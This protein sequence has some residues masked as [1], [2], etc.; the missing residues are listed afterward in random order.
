MS[1]WTIAEIRAALIRRD[2]GLGRPY[3]EV[4]RAS[5]I[6]LAAKSETGLDGCRLRAS[7]GQ[8]DDA[9]EMGES[10]GAT[11]S[12]FRPVEL[13]APPSRSCRYRCACAQR[14]AHRGAERCRSG[15]RL[16]GGGW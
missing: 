16:S 13:V 10:R 8:P 6:D 9:P 12:A 11:S 15:G 7:W 5:G 4:A 3:P 2:V 1:E 14:P